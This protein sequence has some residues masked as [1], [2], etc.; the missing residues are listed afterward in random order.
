MSPR[1]YITPESVDHLRALDDPAELDR[2]GHWLTWLLVHGHP[3]IRLDVPPGYSQSNMSMVSAQLGDLGAVLDRERIKPGER[4]YGHGVPVR[5]WLATDHRGKAVRRAKDEPPTVP[6]SILAGGAAKAAKAAKGTPKSV[7]LD[8]PRAPRPPK[9]DP[10]LDLLRPA[11]PAPTLGAPL[12]V[13]MIAETN[14]HPTIG[15]RDETGAV[16]FATLDG[17]PAR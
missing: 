7:A 12:R 11:A 10:R 3:V 16:Y 6:A 2:V 4:G 9:P 5:L 13:V 14:G 15:L 17:E 1:P 8:I